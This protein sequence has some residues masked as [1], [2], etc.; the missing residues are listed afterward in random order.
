MVSLIVWTYILNSTLIIVH[1]I[2][3]AYWKEWELFG[4]PGGISG[5]LLLHVPLVMLLFFGLIGVYLGTGFGYI[6]NLVVAFGGVFAFFIHS[7]FIQ[8]GNPQFKTITS[9]ALLYGLLA[10]SAIQI[11]LIFKFW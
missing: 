1:E 9:Q 7:Y 10:T 11:Y 4:L 5:F 6:T 8:A 2:D 3:S